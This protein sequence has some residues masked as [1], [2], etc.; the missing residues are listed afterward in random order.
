MMPVLDLLQRG[1]EFP[2]QLF[3]DA[4]AEDLRDLVGG[5][6]LEAHLATTLEDPVNGEVALE[7]EI[8]AVLDLVDRV[9]PA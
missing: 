9:E 3:G 1:V 6:P 2:L 5:Q 4:A 8:A 7:D